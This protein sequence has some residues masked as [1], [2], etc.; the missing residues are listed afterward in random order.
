MNYTNIRNLCKR[1][2]T[3]IFNENGELF[4]YKNLRNK[5]NDHENKKHNLS[6]K[7][8]LYNSIKIFRRRFVRCRTGYCNVSLYWKLISL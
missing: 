1:Y 3:N 5:I 2:N 4:K 7:Q 6:Q 8:K